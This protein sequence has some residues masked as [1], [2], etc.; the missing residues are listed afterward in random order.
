M[1]MAPVN[2][3][4]EQKGT[5]DEITISKEHSSP[6]AAI[7]CPEN[8]FGTQGLSQASEARRNCPWLPNGLISIV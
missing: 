5:D 2:K 1:L 8:K 7:G 6:F 4:T 3:K